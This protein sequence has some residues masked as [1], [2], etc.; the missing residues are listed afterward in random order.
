MTEER[1]RQRCADLSVPSER[2]TRE[3]RAD[4]GGARPTQ[5]VRRSHSAR[6]PRRP[7]W[8]PRADPAAWGGRRQRPLLTFR[9]PRP[10]W[11]GDRCP[12]KTG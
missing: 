10:R 3:G 5:F 1:T 8:H 2:Q 4:A 9:V 11:N 6:R 12:P 7:G